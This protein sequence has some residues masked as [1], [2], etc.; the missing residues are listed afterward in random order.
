MLFFL[1]EC[2]H[3]GI[4]KSRNRSCNFIEKKNVIQKNKPKSSDITYTLEKE[5]HYKWNNGL[6]GC[7]YP[8]FFLL[9]DF[10]Q[11]ATS[12]ISHYSTYLYWRFGGFLPLAMW[13]L[14]YTMRCPI[15]SLNLFT[16]TEPVTQ[17]A[18]A[19]EYVWFCAHM[20]GT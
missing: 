10:K 16:E 20:P 8:H 1:S 19:T 14:V 4:R 11:F 17:G 7:Y 2:D 12:Q 6:C 5:T 18:D 13:W 9:L 15:N 3:I